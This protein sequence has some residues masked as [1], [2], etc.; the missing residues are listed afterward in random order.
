MKDAKLLEAL[1]KKYGRDVKVT[2]GS[3]ETNCHALVT[4]LRY[5]NKMYLDADVTD[6]GIMDNT[7]LLYIGP[8]VPD[9]TNDWAN[10]CIH[11]EGKKHFVTRA[12]MIYWSGK[13]FYIWAVLGNYVEE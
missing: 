12:D 8:A 13:P 3:S 11:F 5:K 6:F 9:F 10:T 7:R 2:I 1:L 4:P